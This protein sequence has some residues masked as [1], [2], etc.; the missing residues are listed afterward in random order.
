M[1]EVDVTKRIEPFLK[2]ATNN[3]EKWSKRKVALEEA[4]KN[5]P[6]RRPFKRSM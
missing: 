3:G 4:T 6:G 2:L 5:Y 1:P